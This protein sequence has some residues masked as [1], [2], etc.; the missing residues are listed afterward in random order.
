MAQGPLIRQGFPLNI[1]LQNL[2]FWVRPWLI[3]CPRATGGTEWYIRIGTLDAK[4]GD[5]FPFDQAFKEDDDEGRVSPLLRVLYLYGLALVRD[6]VDYLPAIYNAT[7]GLPSGKAKR[8]DSRSI[9]HQW[10]RG[11]TRSNGE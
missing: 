3:E 4:N 7:Y 6:G 11:F 2:E 9:P 1:P 8:F 5:S 10:N